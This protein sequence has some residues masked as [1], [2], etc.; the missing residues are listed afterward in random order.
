MISPIIDYLISALNEGFEME[1]VGRQ[2]TD[3]LNNFSQKDGKAPFQIYDADF[4]GAD[5]NPKK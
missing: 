3:N 5:Q 2:I 1:A 4:E